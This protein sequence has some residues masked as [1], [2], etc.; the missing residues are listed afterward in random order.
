MVLFDYF[1]R[2]TQCKSVPPKQHTLQV[3][4]QSVEQQSERMKRTI[5]GWMLV[6]AEV[7]TSGPAEQV[8]LLR[9]WPDQFLGLCKGFLS[10]HMLVQAAWKYAC[11]SATS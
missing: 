11:F 8:Q 3:S 1:D 9:P 7:Y 10:G 6:R 5:D 4:K 2:A